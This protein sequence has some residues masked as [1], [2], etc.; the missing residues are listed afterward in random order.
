MSGWWLWPSWSALTLYLTHR[1]VS[2]KEDDSQVEGPLHSVS[3]TLS[4]QQIFLSKQI[5][6]LMDGIK[7][8]EKQLQ[9]MKKQQAEME[10]M[11]GQYEDQ[12]KEMTKRINAIEAVSEWWESDW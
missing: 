7:E 3:Q 8:R 5:D 11:S 6:T 1:S 10:A 4:S 12:L 9:L 2:E